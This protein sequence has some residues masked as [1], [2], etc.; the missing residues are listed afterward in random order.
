MDREVIEIALGIW[1]QRTTRQ[2]ASTSVDAEPGPPGKEFTMVIY[3]YI[4]WL[5]HEIPPQ[6]K[7]NQDP[8]RRTV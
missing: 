4:R 8:S 5:L 3:T 6:E 2:L 1:D 7:E